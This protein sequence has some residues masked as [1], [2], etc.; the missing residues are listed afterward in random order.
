MSTVGDWPRVSVVVAARNAAGTLGPCLE[1]L[2]RLTY[3]KVEI[4][5]ADDGSSD[6]TAAIALRSGAMVVPS[7][8]RGPS[9]ARNLAVAR[10]TG[11]VL[12]FTDA[13]CTV[14][15]G[16]LTA[17]VAALRTAGVASAGG[18]Q[19]NAVGGVAASAESSRLDAFFRFVSIV[20]D[21]TRS[22][23][24][25]REVAHNA[26]CTSAYWRRAFE[27]AGGFREGLW[28]GEDVDLDRRV[29][30]CGHRCL[31]TPDA[32]VV[33]HRPAAQG[34]LWSTMWRYGAAQARLVVLHGPFRALHVLPI[35]LVLA[36]AAQALLL[37]WWARPLVVAI[38]LLAG[39]AG[40]LMLARAAHPSMWPAVVRQLAV[41]LVA[42]HAGFF[43]T[44]LRPRQWW[45][46]QDVGDRP[47][48]G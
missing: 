6:D 48:S 7:N 34:W 23:T 11:E 44:L 12:A 42:W 45:R 22:A 18:R 43:G 41:S 30:L 47:P 25:P 10:A 35:V 32:V 8:G 14:D 40:L 1:S 27:E 19:V 3:P 37:V 46:R 36:L 28:P 4:L 2:G 24:G 16:W 33:H 39:A 17:L 13:D 38:D 26:S 5:V 31:F 15:P 20:S 9:A 29:R 21:Y